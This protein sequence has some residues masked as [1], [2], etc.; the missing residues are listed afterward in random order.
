MSMTKK[1][2]LNS[3]SLIKKKNE[4]ESQ[5]LALFDSSNSPNLVFSFDYSTLLAQNLSNFVSLLWKLHNRYCHNPDST[6][7]VYI[8]FVYLRV[9]L[10]CPPCIFSQRDHISW[11][12]H[13]KP[14]TETS[15]ISLQIYMFSRGIQYQ[16]F[17]KTDLQSVSNCKGQ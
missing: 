12:S 7:F 13:Q 11:S 15:L 2:L 4:K 17:Q 6:N 9:G 5:I 8:M 3:Y 10:H 1:L 14:I 16:I